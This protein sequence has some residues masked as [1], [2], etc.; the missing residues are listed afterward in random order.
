[1]SDRIATI[2]RVTKIFRDV[3]ND[4][5]L[6][7][8]EDTSATHVP[9]WDSFNHI[10]L[11]MRIEEEFNITFE[12]REIGAMATVKDLVDLIEVKST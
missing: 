11:I 9:G 2:D 5:D 8:S 4:D 12:A 6:N 10:N 7:I 1:M 3:F